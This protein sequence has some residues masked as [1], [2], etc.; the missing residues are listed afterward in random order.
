MKKCP[1]CKLD[2]AIDEAWRHYS[3]TSVQ[4]AQI[5]QRRIIAKEGLEHACDR[6]RIPLNIIATMKKSL[7]GS[8]LE[9]AMAGNERRMA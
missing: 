9:A 5:C 6:H 7:P 1:F 2:R 3:L 8:V 4:S